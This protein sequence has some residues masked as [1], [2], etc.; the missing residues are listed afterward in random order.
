MAD[1]QQFNRRSSD[2]SRLRA[3]S[4]HAVIIA[5]A[6]LTSIIG[7]PAGLAML[8]WLATST[9]S[10]D[11]TVAVLNADF[12]S[13]T[14]MIERDFKSRDARLDAIERRVGLTWR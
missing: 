10:V 8:G 5:G 14:N 13:L 1:E 9:I 7:V 2:R 12:R 6:R 4:E 3:V 11:K